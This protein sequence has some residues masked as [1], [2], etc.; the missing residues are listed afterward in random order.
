MHF[1][2]KS[3]SPSDVNVF[4]SRQELSNECLLANIGVDTAEDETLKAPDYM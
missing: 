1:L 4:R 2:E 3:R